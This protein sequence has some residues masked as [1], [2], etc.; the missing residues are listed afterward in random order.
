MSGRLERSI[1]CFSD[2]YVGRHVKGAGCRNRISS[3]LST[4]RYGP[5]SKALN[6]EPPRESPS[7]SNNTREIIPRASAIEYRVLFVKRERTFEVL[8]I[9]PLYWDDETNADC[10]TLSPR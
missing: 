6:R 5:F 2:R 1:S 8:E 9:I 4:R 10:V 3:A 7:K